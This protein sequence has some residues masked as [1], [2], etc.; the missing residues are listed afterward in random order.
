MGCNM[1]VKTH[2]LESHLEF[3][4][5]NVGQLSDEQGE[6]G[7]QDLK[8]MEKRYLGK[9]LINAIADHCWSLC[10]KGNEGCFEGKNKRK[11]FVT[12]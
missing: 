4:P 1:T 5:S 3:F 2:F 10:R 11:Y 7:H 6:R 9:N 12:E 8:K